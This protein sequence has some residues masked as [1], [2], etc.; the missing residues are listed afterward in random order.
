MGLF[1][2]NDS[3]VDHREANSQFSIPVCVGRRSRDAEQQ[4]FSAFGIITRMRWAIGHA[5]SINPLVLGKVE[6]NLW[7]VVCRENR[8]FIVAGGH[9]GGVHL[10]ILN[11]NEGSNEYS[12]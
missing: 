2:K 10:W 6:E 11:D 4:V 1:D 5:C 9:K 8:Q 12:R 3:F 7:P